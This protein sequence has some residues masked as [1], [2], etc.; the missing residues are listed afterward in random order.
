MTDIT[1][2]D[3]S[4]GQEIVKRSGDRATPLWST[5]VM[6]EKPDVVGDVHLDYFRAGATI[7]T[8]NTYAVYVDRLDRVGL[9]GEHL[10][11][12]D[13]AVEQAQ[14]ARTAHGSGRIAGA[15]GPLGA[16]YRPD[17]AIEQEKAAETFAINVRHLD[18]HVDLFLIETASSLHQ[19]RTALMGCARATDKP[20]WLSVTVKDDD[21]TQLR[22]GE[23]I[24]DLAGIVSEFDPA[25]VLINCSP[26]EAMAAG[27]EIV[28]TFGKPFGAYANG[29][30]RISED[31]L[32]EAPTVDA[33]EQRTDLGP[34]EYAAF[35]MGWID[36][37]AT[38][39]G[40]CCEVGPAHI[41]ELARQLRAAG[42]TIT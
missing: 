34:K 19:A 41:A 21:G 32:K 1:L 27:L 2:L 13:V 26:P 14:R 39:V 30:T 12:L 7:A 33:L 11:L 28:K 24:A 36:Q 35:A 17:I 31:F 42:H 29:F 15:L 20:V 10:H 3:G 18:P 37:G 38:I 5:S 4:I 23:S 40:G 9:E 22:S 16:T 8:T 25:A 6:M